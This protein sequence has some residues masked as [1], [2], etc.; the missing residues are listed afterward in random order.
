MTNLLAFQAA[1]AV[2]ICFAIV[3][4]VSAFAGAKKGFIKCV[5]GLV[6]T[7][8]AL[9]LAITLA[10]TVAGLLPSVFGAE[11]SLAGKLETTFVKWKGFDTDISASGVEAALENVTLPGFIKDSIV[12]MAGEMNDLPEGATLASLAAP[13]VAQFLGL[14]ICGILIFIVA[15]LLLLLIEKI[16]TKIVNSWGLAAMLNRTLGFAAGLL[17][18]LIFICGAL[19][20]LSLIPVEGITTFFDKT[21]VLKYLYHQNPLPKLW[22]LF[23]KG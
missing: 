21:L 6:A 19:A 7:L 12:K 23:I 9:I 17:E 1:Y 5:F 4:L 18:A 11:G 2:D 20:I 10:S 3:L 13:V 15:R 16:L 14:L 22:G 8:V